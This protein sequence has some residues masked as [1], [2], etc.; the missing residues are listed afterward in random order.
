[1][2]VVVLVAVLVFDCDKTVVVHL[3]PLTESQRW[4]YLWVWGVLPPHRFSLRVAPPPRRWDGAR[5]GTSNASFLPSD[6]FSVMN[7]SRSSQ[8]QK[9]VT[10]AGCSPPPL[11]PRPGTPPP[12]PSTTPIRLLVCE[13][14]GLLLYSWCSV[15]NTPHPSF[16]PPLSSPTCPCRRKKIKN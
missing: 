16:P 8:A 12:P 15:H 13:S 7:W 14:T 11:W 2:L 1:M 6:A 4:V 9:L 10:L 3:C 5:S